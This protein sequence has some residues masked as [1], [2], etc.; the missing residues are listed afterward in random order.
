M[1][2]NTTY[3]D[4]K[5]QIAQ[6]IEASGIIPDAEVAYDIDAILDETCEFE[7]QRGFYQIATTSEFW[8]AVAAHE[9]AP[10]E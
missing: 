3:R 7:A 8:L 6:A 1:S 10:A 4:A 9:K 2:K 5:A